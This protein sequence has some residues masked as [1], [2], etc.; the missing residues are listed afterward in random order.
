LELLRGQVPTPDLQGHHL[1]HEMHGSAGSGQGSDSER[2]Y[3]GT[4]YTLHR[5]EVLGDRRRPQP[6]PPKYVFEALTQ[7]HR[8][9]HRRWLKL[10]EDEV[11]PKVIESREHDLVVWSSI[12]QMHPLARI[13]FELEPERGGGTQLRW[14]LTDE[15]DPGPASVGHMR[16]RVQQLINAEL[17]FSFGQ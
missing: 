9:P 4:A 3:R 12:W 2:T 5:M 1:A 15:V 8:D 13:R 7:P 17:R 10:L 6:A 14:I 16:K 11:E